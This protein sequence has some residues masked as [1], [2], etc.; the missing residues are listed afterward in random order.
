MKGLPN[1]FVF[2]GINVR[3]YGMLMATAMLIGIILGLKNAKYRNMVADNIY[4]LA[5]VVLPLAIIGARLFFVLGADR[6][7]TFWEI[8]KTWEG[9]MSIYGGIIGG[10]IGV[11]LYCIIYEKNFLDLAD[12]AAVSLALG[13]AIGRW[14]NFFNQE[15][16]GHI[17]ENPS[18]QWF[19]FAVLLD[20]GEWHYALFFYEFLIN[21]AIFAVL[22]VLIRRIKTRGYVMG[23]YLVMYGAIRFLLEPLR[24]QEYNLMLFGLKLSSLTSA[25]AVLAGII[26]LVWIYT[27]SR[28]GVNGKQE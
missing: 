25:I 19:P 3:F 12:V 9:G 23:L 28:R 4:V 21:L 20:N 27:K 16:Y 5:L 1:G 11:A 24:E 2:L 6:S 13:Q 8:F 18:M 7:Y 10:A 15:V 22:F 26:S 17:V 14:G